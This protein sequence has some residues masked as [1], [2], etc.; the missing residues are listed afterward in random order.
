MSQ[1]LLIQ[2]V[3]PKKH[4]ESNQQQQQQT[5]LGTTFGM[6]KLL[7]EYEQEIK[8]QDSNQIELTQS[9]L[10]NETFNKKETN[11]NLD[12][13]VTIDDRKESTLIYYELDINGL[14][15][16]LDYVELEIK[17]LIHPE[18]YYQMNNND[19]KTKNEIIRL[20]QEQKGL[21]NEMD[22]LSVANVIKD[23]LKNV[24][25]NYTSRSCL[26]DNDLLN[27]NLE[28]IND[29][30]VRS[31]L[32][33]RSDLNL[34]DRLL[35]HFVI[36]RKMALIDSAT[37]GQLFAHALVNNTYKVDKAI[38]IL[39]KLINQET[40]E[41]SDLLADTVT[42]TSINKELQ[43]ASSS[44]LRNSSA[45]QQFIMSSTQNSNKSKDLQNDSDDDNDEID[46]LVAPKSAGSTLNESNK[47]NNV[48]VNSILKSPR[49]SLSKIYYLFLFF[50]FMY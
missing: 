17:H 6:N 21:L 23:E 33:N 36:V 42:E 39:E 4:T 2:T 37:I 12:K 22:S 7:K 48:I 16:L 19:N 29:N 41:H 45:Y 31:Y 38:K 47:T 11:N 3:S 20:A 30:L 10:L 35:K 46:A 8:R 14:Y 24:I 27:E 43:M 1:K 49:K 5:D 34:W 28:N 25:T 44:K 50:L 26:F 15:N 9:I 40:M 18:N 32:R 13:T